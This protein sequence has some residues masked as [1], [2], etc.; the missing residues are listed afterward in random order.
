MMQVA[1]ATAVTS[2]PMVALADRPE[3][4]HGALYGISCDD[5]SLVR[6]DL[7]DA[8][9]D[10]I[11]KVRLSNGKVLTGIRAA[12]YRQ[13]YRTMIAF[14]SDPASGQSYAVKV[15]LSTGE[16]ELCPT[17]LVTGDFT[18]A[19]AVRVPNASGNGNSWSVFALMQ[20]A[21][22][23]TGAG[24]DGKININPSNSADNE[25]QV[26]FAAGTTL[27]LADGTVVTSL[28]RDDL[29]DNAVLDSD[30]VAFSGSVS[31]V[32]VKPKGNSNDNVMTLDGDDYELSNSETYEFEGTMQVTI[33]NDHLKNGMAMGKW[34]MTLEATDGV[35][36][37]GEGGAPGTTNKLVRVDPEGGTTTPVMTLDGEYESL[38]GTEGGTVFYVTKGNTLYKIDTDAGTI[39]AIGPINPGSEAMEMF[40]DKLFAYDDGVNRVRPIN[41][42]NGAW[43]G[44]GYSVNLDGMGSLIYV[45]P[46]YD[47]MKFDKRLSLD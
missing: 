31:R 6:Y 45:D 12:A 43:T 27:T 4:E 17:P 29:K 38:A 41:A 33:W 16:S 35:T 1:V 3:L 42:G 26:D 11:G 47:P 24:V 39:T 18:G 20:A 36:I 8:G 25:F 15:D 22:V 9:T 40:G 14:W 19:T 7:F 23:P 32:R 30:G 2:L 5:G 28:S 21:G 13:G 34:W 44:D 10:N 37:N 46:V